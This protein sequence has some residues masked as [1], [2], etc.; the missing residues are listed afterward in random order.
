MF[1]TYWR[2]RDFSSKKRTLA[3]TPARPRTSSARRKRPSMSASFARRQS[4]PPTL[5]GQRSHRGNRPR[6]NACTRLIPFWLNRW[7]RGGSRETRH[8][9][10]HLSFFS[11]TP[12]RCSNRDLLYRVIHQVSDYIATLIWEFKHVTYMPWQPCQFCQICSCPSR[13]RQTSELPNQSQ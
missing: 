2:Y 9:G 13:I 5:P 10:H 6:W 12:L 7:N 4:W 1:Y 8:S 11:K 3:S